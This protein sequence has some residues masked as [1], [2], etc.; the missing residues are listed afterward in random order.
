MNIDNKFAAITLIE[1]LYKKGM[2]NQETYKNVLNYSGQM[3]EGK[4]PHIS[5]VT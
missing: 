3:C 2:I 4:G 5:Q 1:V